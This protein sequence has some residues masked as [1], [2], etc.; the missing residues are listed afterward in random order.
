MKFTNVEISTLWESLEDAI[1]DRESFLEAYCDPYGRPLKGS[2]GIIR[3]TKRIIARY[4]RLQEKIA[5]GDQAEALH[6][7]TPRDIV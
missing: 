4:R 3:L 6:P 1:R 7:A 2:M 5:V